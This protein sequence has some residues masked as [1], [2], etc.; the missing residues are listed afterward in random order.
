MTDRVEE[1]V[2]RAVQTFLADAPDTDFQRGF[3]AALLVLA[4]EAL[5][6]RLDSPPFAE[7]QE[8]QSYDLHG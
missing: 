1:Y 2:T 3:L 5:E 7:A 8:L 4:E 6:L